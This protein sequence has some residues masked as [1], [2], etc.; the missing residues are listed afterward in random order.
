MLLK[1]RKYLHRINIVAVIAIYI[2]LLSSCFP[3]LIQKTYV[4][5]PPV[6]CSFENKGD[7]KLSGKGNFSDIEGNIAYAV[8]DKW[9]LTAKGLFRT[10][11]GA[12]FSFGGV[13]YKN[14]SNA[15][16]EIASGIGYYT[17]QSVIKSY[18]FYL[19]I[20]TDNYYYHDINCCYYNLYIQPT[21]NIKINERTELGF[22]LNIDNVYF[23]DYDYSFK[24]EPYQGREERPS[25]EI[26]ELNYSNFNALM[27]EPTFTYKYNRSKRMSFFYQ[28]G[29]S[30]NTIYYI[31]NYYYAP[32]Y[33][34]ETIRH[35]KYIHP[36]YR[37]IILNFGISIK[38]GK[39]E[40]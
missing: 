27:I 26:D 34:S 4:P 13:R 19:P 18:G 23:K 11:F 21:W 32:Y 37:H 8:S 15:Y 16:F 9:G 35:F 7:I 28:M 38:L 6:A 3:Q 36:V 29:Y 25:K 40:N 2:V 5:N 14:Y 12:G 22:G 33:G 24:I 31:S 10:N 30:F 17:F 20:L 1:K 39:I